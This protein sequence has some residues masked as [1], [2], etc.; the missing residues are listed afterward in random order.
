MAAVHSVDNDIGI[1]WSYL[2]DNNLLHDT[3]VWIFSDHGFSLGEYGLWCKHRI[4]ERD[5]H[6]PLTL[7]VPGMRP[8]AYQHPVELLDVAPTTMSLLGVPVEACAS[9]CEYSPDLC[10]DGRVI[11]PHTEIAPRVSRSEYMYKARGTTL[12]MAY[13]ITTVDGLRFAR[14]VELDTRSTFGPATTWS[15]SRFDAWIMYNLTSDPSESINIV[16]DN[17]TLKRE[18]EVLLRSAFPQCPDNTT[19]GEEDRAPG[20]EEGNDSMSSSVTA[21]PTLLVLFLSALLCIPRFRKKRKMPRSRVRLCRRFP[22]QNI[23]RTVSKH[24]NLNIPDK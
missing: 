15:S 5:T 7:Y 14:K 16:H 3:L 17:D 12:V 10:V 23:T 4:F 19:K 24:N 1:V 13:S 2:A 20:T 11:Y 18:M 21:P 8:S 9:V 6:V 22:R